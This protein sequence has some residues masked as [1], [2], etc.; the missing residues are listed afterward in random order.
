VYLPTIW[1]RW[2]PKTGHKAADG[3]RGKTT[4][5]IGGFMGFANGGNS[6]L[7]VFI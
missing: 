5:A 2:Q 6:F 3:I 1:T 7:F 4:D